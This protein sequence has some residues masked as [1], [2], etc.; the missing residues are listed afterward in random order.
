MITV[1]YLGLA[2]S[3]PNKKTNKQKE[4]YEYELKTTHLKIKTNKSMQIKINWI[5][6]GES[7]LS[8]TKINL[9]KYFN[10]VGTVDC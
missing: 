10:L 8:K 9:K 7:K 5:R 3:E 2:R 4:L 1:L 6:G